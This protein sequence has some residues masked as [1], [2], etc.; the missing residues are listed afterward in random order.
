MVCCLCPRFSVD[1]LV[2]FWPGIDYLGVR[3]GHSTTGDQ[4][5]S[6]QG[7]LGSW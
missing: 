5:Y 7:E 4:L 3:D 6:G 1:M 2:V